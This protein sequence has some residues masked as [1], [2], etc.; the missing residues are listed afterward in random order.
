MDNKWKLS[1]LKKRASQRKKQQTMSTLHLI[2]THHMILSGRLEGIHK[3]V[4]QCPLLWSSFSV[5]IVSWSFSFIKLIYTSSGHYIPLN[6]LNYLLA[7]F[8]TIISFCNLCTSQSI[9]GKIYNITSEHC[10][11]LHYFLFL[12]RVLVCVTFVRYKETLFMHICTY[13]YIE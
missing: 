8:I 11:A 5:P 1:V 9:T 4:S 6:L 12:Y 3:S 2:L 7:M 13:V 10:P